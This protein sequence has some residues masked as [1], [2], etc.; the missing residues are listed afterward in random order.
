MCESDIVGDK[1]VT[2][3]ERVNEDDFRANITNGGKD[4]EIHAYR[5]T[6]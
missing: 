4:E 1:I 5:G 6:V 3:M 2:A